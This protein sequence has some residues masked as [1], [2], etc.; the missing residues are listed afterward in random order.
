MIGIPETDTLE[1]SRISA[2]VN[3]GF[4]LTTADGRQA[5]LAIIDEDGNVIEAGQAVAQEAWNVC[6][7]VQK[8]F[9][10]GM[11]HLVVH[12][13]PPGIAKPANVA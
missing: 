2:N 8:N 12:S 9:W 13:E 10:R 11:G 7:A 4:Q 1:H 6:I 5:H 3:T